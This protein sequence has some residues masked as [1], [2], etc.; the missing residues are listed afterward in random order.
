MIS[1]STSL[2]SCRGLPLFE[3]SS[4]SRY[5]SARKAYLHASKGYRLRAYYK[6]R[7]AL[8]ACLRAGVR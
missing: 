7:E 6:M 8:H 1:V 3:A 4:A 2:K 5:E